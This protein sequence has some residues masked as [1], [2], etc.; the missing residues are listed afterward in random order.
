MIG[1]Y[2]HP[3][4]PNIFLNI[5]LQLLVTPAVSLLVFN[6]CPFLGKTASAPQNIGPRT[7]M[8]SLSYSPIITLDTTLKVTVDILCMCMKKE[9]DSGKTVELPVATTKSSIYTSRTLTV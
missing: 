3:K 5:D 4:P 8:Y 9:Q 1:L 7:P 2:L 6:A